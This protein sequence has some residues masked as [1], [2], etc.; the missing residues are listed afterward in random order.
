M[1]YKH[2][3]LTIEFEAA[4]PHVKALALYLDHYANTKLGK[5]LL[6]TDV[7]RTHEE[8]NDLY[9]ANPYTGPMPHL[10]P[11]SR[12]IDFR[13]VGE[14][15]DTQ[16]AMLVDHMNSCWKRKDLKPTAM[17]HNVGAGSHIHLQAEI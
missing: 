14:L 15:S 7:S 16:V 3:A 10:G 13:T 2:V 4:H 11:E 8:Y 9:H 6:I 5:D 12:A 1:R 17:F